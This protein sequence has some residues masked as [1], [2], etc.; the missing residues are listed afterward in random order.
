MKI[1]RII[2]S[3]PLPN[4]QNVNNPSLGW[5]LSRVTRLWRGV[6]SQ[7]V[8]PMEMTEA[9]WSAMMN[10][11]MLGEGTSQ[12]MLATELGIEMPSLTRTVNQLVNLNLVERRPHPS[13]GRCHCLWF[14]P[15]G[16]ECIEMLTGSVNMVRAE[17]T[18]GISN[19]ELN[20]LFKVLRKLEQNASIMLNKYHVGEK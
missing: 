7:A 3:K 19:D 9:R 2:M 1:V 20:A 11:K 13:D 14:T 17:L 12:H 5:L 15:A 16:S 10:L 4:K 8:N 18:K 6:I